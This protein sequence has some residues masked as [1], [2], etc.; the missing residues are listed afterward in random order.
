MYQKFIKPHSFLDLSLPLEV[1]SPIEEALNDEEQLAESGN[2]VS[3][4][5]FDEVENIV[6]QQ[7]A[8]SLH[9]FRQTQVYKQVI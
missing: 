1:V 7:L 6:R 9:L 2:S 8:P 5:F 3:K 4:D